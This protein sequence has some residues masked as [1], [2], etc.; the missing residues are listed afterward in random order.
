MYHQTK[1]ERSTYISFAR[2]RIIIGMCT[3]MSSTMYN[4]V[5]QFDHFVTLKS[6]VSL[7]VDAVS[8]KSIP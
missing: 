2:C 5:L 8:F 6:V 3:M 4:S 7:L 1:T